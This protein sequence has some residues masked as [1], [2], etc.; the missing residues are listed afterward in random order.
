VVWR[1]GVGWSVCACVLWVGGFLGG[2]EEEGGEEGQGWGFWG[3]LVSF[4]RSD[5][6]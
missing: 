4:G 5:V 2:S 1:G 3:G 6:I